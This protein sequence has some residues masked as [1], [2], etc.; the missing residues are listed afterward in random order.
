MYAYAS[1]RILPLVEY[2]CPLLCRLHY[3]HRP[4]DSIG[5][6]VFLYVGSLPEHFT[7]RQVQAVR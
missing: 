5:S 6:V 3:R 1:I 4:F 2:R 7:N